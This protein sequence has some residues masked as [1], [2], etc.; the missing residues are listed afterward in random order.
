MTTPI[1]PYR[2]RMERVRDK[3]REERIQA[4]IIPSNDP[5]SSEYVPDYWKGREWVS[6]FTG[7]A[8]TL[9]ITLDDAGMWTD[10]RYFVQAEQQLEG[11]GIRLFRDRLPETPS[12]EQWLATQLQPHE[13]VGINGW[14]S[15]IGDVRTW[16]EVLTEN[17][18]KLRDVGDLLIEIWEKRP[19]LPV[20]AVEELPISITGRSTADKLADL[21]S[22]L[23]K[24]GC[25][26]MLITALDEIAWLL[27]MRGSDV[28]CNPVF[29]SYLLMT[30]EY[31][32]LYIEQKKLTEDVRRMLDEVGIVP[33]HY[34]QIEFDLA[35]L[36]NERLLVPPTTNWRLHTLMTNNQEMETVVGDSPVRIAKA[37]KNE[38]EIAG[39]RQAML[40]D[41][42]AMVRFL[43]WLE[44]AIGQE[45]LSEC[46]VSKRLLSFRQE[47]PGFKGISFD[48]IAGYAGNGAIVHYEATPETDCLIE[49]RNFLLLD[50]GGQYT[51]GTTDITRTIPMGELTDE[52][53]R[54]YTLVLKGMIA[55]SRIQFPDGSSGT[56][57][58]V[59]ARQ[60]MWQQGINYGHGTGHGV[61]HFLNVH[62]GPHQIRMNY[63]SAPLRAGMTITN[64]PGI[65]RPGSHGVRIENTM[66]IVEGAQTEFGRFLR[67]SPLTLCPIDCR[68]IVMDMMQ[69]EEV[70]WLDT[71][72]RRVYDELSPY[73]TKEEGE[74]LARVTRPLKEQE[75]EP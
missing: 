22:R 45:T 29:V 72:H 33:N 54:D 42:V 47:Q 48:T 9:V 31:T 73:L 7:S 19:S 60:F 3:M 34:G 66:L 4:Y 64:E 43:R 74:W 75:L 8:G 50:S 13:V 28:H 67:F 20:E 25:T 27:N 44:T 17:E 6:G 14:T 16:N 38:T 1:N 62:E 37:I 49:P 18:I 23:D 59:L 57:L 21:R 52:Q 2:E 26:G 40:Y 61:G 69:D 41:G 70:A 12:I 55:L 53:R 36:K 65:Y 71:Y 10:S 51:C 5:H 63:V 46:S 24:S 15:T 35:T 56:Q 30:H 58:D 39:F 32:Y 11:S 68:P